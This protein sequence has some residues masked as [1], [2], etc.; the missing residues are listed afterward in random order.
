[1]Q[2]VR[3]TE[4]W[5]VREPHPA[6]ETLQKELGIQRLLAAALVDRGILAPEDATEFLNPSLDSLHSPRLLPNCDEAVRILMEAREKG[7]RVFVHGDYDVDGVTSAAI[8]ARALRRLGFDV[9]AHVPHRIKQGFGVHESA[10]FEAMQQQAKVLLTCDCGSSAIEAVK[11]AKQFGMRV[12]ITDHHE[13]GRE[14]PAADAIVNPHLPGNRYPFPFL[15]GAGVA[16]KVAQQV[17]EE[18]GATVRQFQRAFLDLACLGTIADVVPLHGENRVI[19]HFGLMALRRTKKVGIQALMRVAQIEPG[20][21]VSSAEVGWRLGP[22]LNAA[23]R[24]DDAA[25]ALQLLLTDDPDEAQAL[26]QRLD[27]LNEARRSEELRILEQAE[28]TIQEHNLAA[29]PLIMV[30]AEDWH[31]G[32]VGIVAGRICERYNR[33]ALVA[34]VDPELGIA[35]GSARSPEAYNLHDALML[36]REMFRSCGGHARAAGFSVSS[37][38]LEEVRTA[39]VQHAG[40]VLQP[41]DLIPTRR[42]TAAVTPAEVVHR[43]FIELE[44]LEPLGEANPKPLFFM[45]RV[46]LIEIQPTSNPEHIRFRIEAPRPVYGIGFRSAQLFEEFRPGDEVDLLF[47]AEIN[48]YNGNEYP[49]I[50]LEGIRPAEE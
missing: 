24:V 3:T 27:E 26:A 9:I 47:R 36:H 18:C 12:V 22:R 42:A 50:L 39:L 37:D 20:G 1:M 35:F 15:S 30:F 10:V 6:E 8:W 5:V 49:Q 34:A 28:E 19:A 48:R 11:R 33:P 7:Q 44:K 45:P 2:R 29:E 16:F 41:E 38:A 40:A 17:A 23:G 4:R 46:R 13:F 31:R 21:T 14:I 43:S 32:V 25:I